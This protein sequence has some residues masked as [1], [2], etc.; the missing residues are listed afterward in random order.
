MGY[1]E[2]L[3]NLTLEEKASL[4]SGANF[5]ETK[6]IE[7]LGI[8]ALTMSDGPYGIRKQSSEE[9]YLDFHTAKKYIC[10]PT[11][12]GMAAS[13]DRELWY[14][15][16]AALGRECRA[17]NVDILLGPAVNIKRSPLGGR[18]FEYLSEDPLVAGTLGAEYV[19]GLQS[20]GVSACVKHFAVNSQET[21][22]MSVS[23]NADERTLREIYLRVFEIIVKN[24]QP[25]TLMCS[26]N[27][28]NHTFASENKWLLNDVLRKDWGFD[29]LVVTDWGA[30]C[31]RVRGVLAGLDME[32]PSSG[33]EMDALIVEAVREG[34]LKEYELDITVSRILRLIAKHRPECRELPSGQEEYKN[35]PENECVTQIDY[36]A[37]HALAAKIAAESM[38]LLKNEQSV[39]PLPTEGITVALI[40]EF[41]KCPRYEGGGSSHINSWKAESPFEAAKSW[42]GVSFRYARGYQTDRNV[43]DEALLE[44]ALKTAAEA[45]Y[46][47]V[48]AG[49]PEDWESESYDR[50]TL[51]IPENQNQL[52]H[53]ISQIQKNVIVVLQ[54]GSP[55]VMPWLSE[56]SAVL[57]AYLA[58][59]AGGKAV[60]DTLFG[61]NNPGGHLAETFPLRLED[62]PCFLNFPGYQDDADYSEGVFVGYRHYVSRRI[63]V[64]FPFGY[65]L[66]YTE[67]EYGEL[68]LSQEEFRENDCI[69]VRVPVKNTGARA[70][71]ALIQLYVEPD[72]NTYAAA[73][74]LRELKAFSRT[75]LRPGEEKIVELSIDRDAF[76]FYDKDIHDWHLAPGL[77]K[78][79]V[80]SDCESILRE[81]EL[82][83][84]SENKKTPAV[85][86]NSLIGDLLE[87]DTTRPVMEDLLPDMLKCMGVSC[88]MTPDGHINRE[89]LPPFV[90]ELPIRSLI[91]FT[92]GV[93]SEEQAE[94]V[95]RKLKEAE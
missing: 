27:Q 8:P 93:F 22:R 74:P 26:Y 43:S 29:G 37:D 67:F 54:N 25:D 4:C 65:G 81:K 18:N 61:R 58:G 90:Y 82:R 32:M 78:I 20:Q 50:T 80:G 45:D 51:Q 28:I 7:R 35:S 85:S 2:I 24:A 41:A 1:E 46:A 69:K 15:F 30:V 87:H 10:F 40:G 76:V 94:A 36:E 44:E 33:G 77:Y 21:R 64:L 63:P 55:V 48:F 75:E 68:S 17:E 83:V 73:R 79:Q 91:S 42:P 62:T 71:K 49:L 6:P 57:E 53:Q 70:G 86:R 95:V 59:E 31:D 13:F 72:K 47:V 89:S 92:D 38:V 39:L 12:A 5:W 56:V 52:I 19:K 14:E 84:F 60:M 34:R 9:N 23:A 66:S 11:A 16:G 3:R 88:E